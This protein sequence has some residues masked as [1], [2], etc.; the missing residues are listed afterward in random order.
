RSTASRPGARGGPGWRGWRGSSPARWRRRRWSSSVARSSARSARPPPP[1]T[2]S[3]PPRERR[4]RPCARA[5]GPRPPGTIF[6]VGPPG[7]PGHNF[8]DLPDGAPGRWPG[9]TA[10]A[11]LRRE[12]ALQLVAQALERKYASDLPEAM[13]LVKLAL[14]FDPQ[15]PTAQ[16][17]SVDL[18]AARSPDV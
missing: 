1:P 9:S 18:A 15:L 4:A 5:P 13:H 3:G 11:D 12:A 8:K 17:L 14:T 7:P 16:H 10:L 2:L 6:R